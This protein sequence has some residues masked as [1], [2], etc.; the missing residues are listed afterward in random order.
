[1]PLSQFVQE[2]WILCALL[3]IVI[4]AIIVYEI[5]H[6]G[7]GGA[8]VSNVQAGQLVNE[9]AILIDTRTPAEFKAGHIAGAQNVPADSIANYIDKH[10][11]LKDKTFVFYCKTGVST[12]VPAQKMRAAGFKNVYVLKAGIDGWTQDSLPTV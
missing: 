3:G 7:R 11:N 1:M 8:L 5:T 12:K 4:I 9:G 2:N 6:R 10:A